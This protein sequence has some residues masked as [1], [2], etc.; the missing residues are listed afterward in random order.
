MAA[1]FPR[2][3]RSGRQLHAP[4]RGEVVTHNLKDVAYESVF[5]CAPSTGRS[6]PHRDNQSQRFA[7]AG[8]GLRRIGPQKSRRRP[9]TNVTRIS[10]LKPHSRH[11]SDWIRSMRTPSINGYQMS[12]GRSEAVKKRQRRQEPSHPRI[13]SSRNWTT[14]RTILR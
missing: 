1:L 6:F 8:L 11:S 10:R 3:R 5:E 7:I 14:Y 2:S 4:T 9:R 12:D 13:D